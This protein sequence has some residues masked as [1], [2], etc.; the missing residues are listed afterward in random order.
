MLLLHVCS[1]S[2]TLGLEELCNATETPAPEP[3]KE[4]D[5]AVLS[6]VP[7]TTMLVESS[8]PEEPPKSINKEA[9]GANVG[10]EPPMG[11][12]TKIEEESLEIPS[13]KLMKSPSP[14]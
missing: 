5:V 4:L 3:E 10:D 9:R 12:R 8:V 1:P 11:E 2:S 7:A 6:A 13:G 14:V